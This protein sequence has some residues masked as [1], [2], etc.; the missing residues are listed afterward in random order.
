VFV[1]TFLYNRLP[2]CGTLY[3]LPVRHHWGSSPV[4]MFGYATHTIRH[5]KRGDDMIVRLFIACA[6]LSTS[7][8]M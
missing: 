2:T 8:P 6:V 7:L 5:I 3:V 4:G 1:N